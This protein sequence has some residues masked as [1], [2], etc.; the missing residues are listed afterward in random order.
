MDRIAVT[1]VL[2]L[3]SLIPSITYTQWLAATPPPSCLAESRTGLRSA[4]RAYTRGS[5]MT[6]QAQ[7]NA[8][9]LNSQKS[10]GP[11][12]PEGK[13]ASSLN[14][15]KSG[16]HAASHIICGE[17]P[18][19]LQAL[20]AAFLLEFQPTGPNQLALVDTL[21]AAE[22][23]QRRLRRIEAELWNS[24]DESLDPTHA[25]ISD[26][27][28][29]ARLP[30]SPLRH[31]YPDAIDPFLRIQ[32]RIDG[33]NRMYLR[34]LQVLQD[35]V[36]AGHA[37]PEPAA[38]ATSPAPE[39]PSPEGAQPLTPPNGFVPPTPASG[40]RPPVRPE[41]HES[42]SKAKPGTAGLR[43][44]GQPATETTHDDR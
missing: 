31:Y 7:I 30:N 12:S 40:Q 21:I 24:R 1:S 32:R 35:L 14:A 27:P 43:Q 5:S 33:T 39:P 11:T 29:D 38:Q 15:L 34:T 9:R 37:R 10:T 17:D 28:P 44:I 19:A 36:G 20:T 25:E 42:P 2:K 8:N 13:A 22:W 26:F 16:I 6:S 23:T 4:G 18:A 3:P 41:N